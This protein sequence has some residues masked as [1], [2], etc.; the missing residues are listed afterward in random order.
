MMMYSWPWTG[1]TVH[2]LV[3]IKLVQPD[4]IQALYSLV[5]FLM[6]SGRWRRGNNDA[7]GLPGI[8]SVASAATVGKQGS[9]YGP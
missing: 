4:V 6:W 5:Y 7:R 3:T 9:D 8:E 1:K 2:L